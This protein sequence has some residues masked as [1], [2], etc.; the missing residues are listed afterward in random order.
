[1]LYASVKE[2]HESSLKALIDQSWLRRFNVEVSSSNY[3]YSGCDTYRR[4]GDEDLAFLYHSDAHTV[5][6]CAPEVY[7]DI[8]GQR[9]TNLYS[10]VE[11]NSA[12]RYEVYFD[13]VDYYLFGQYPTETTEAEIVELTLE[14]DRQIIEQFI[15]SCDDEDIR[16]ADL[17]IDSD[18]F[19]AV[20]KGGVVA[21]ML[22]SYCGIEPFESLSILVRPPYRQMGLGKSLLLHLMQ[23]VQARQRMVRYRC[24]IDNLASIRLCESLGFRPYGRIQVLARL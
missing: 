12:D 21:A 8:V 22:A 11:Q 1:M 10:Y 2:N 23:Q 19:Y 15:A 9:M 17:D 3:H 18:Y 13:D 16:K 6:S 5:V 7:G 24:N 14:K 20:M 4:G